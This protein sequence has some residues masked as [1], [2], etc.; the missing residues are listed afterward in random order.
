M[1]GPRGVMLRS[2]SEK[3]VLCKFTSMW[4]LK[5]E[6]KRMS[7]AERDTDTKNRHVV[8]RGVEGEGY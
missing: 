6:S 3:Q 1:D 5:A 7:K 2:K 8:V 4:D